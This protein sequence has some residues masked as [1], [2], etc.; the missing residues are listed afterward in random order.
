MNTR[1]GNAQA[2]CGA[3]AQRLAPSLLRPTFNPSL[4]TSPLL[5]PTRTADTAPPSVVCHNQARR[6]RHDFHPQI[7]ENSFSTPWDVVQSQKFRY[8]PLGPLDPEDARQVSPPP[9]PKEYWQ[10]NFPGE[11]NVSN[12]YASHARMAPAGIRSQIQGEE[13]YNVEMLRNY[14]KE[15]PSIE[16]MQDG[17]L[18]YKSGF[19]NPYCRN[20]L[21]IGKWMLIGALAAGSSMWLYW[22]F[23]VFKTIDGW[24]ANHAKPLRVFMWINFTMWCLYLWFSPL[25]AYPI[26][27][28]PF[29]PGSWGALEPN[30]IIGGL[31]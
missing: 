25:D 6:F 19:L 30:P 31:Q 8:V 11:V 4:A 10:I 23:M 3:S 17:T 28:W 7:N 12:K 29:S 14:D 9:P 27:I 20:T 5:W 24:M 13:Y 1:L 15:W 26:P 16:K 18:L 2:P 22:W 21:T